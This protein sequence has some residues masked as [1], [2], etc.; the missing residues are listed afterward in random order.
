MLLFFVLSLV[1]GYTGRN[2]IFEQRIASNQFQS[3]TSFDAAEAGLDW[4][5]SQLNGSRI[6]NACV[7]TTDLTRDKF[8]DRYLAIDPANGVVTPRTDTGGAILWTACVFNGADWECSCPATGAPSLAAPVGTGS[9]PAFAVRFEA[10]TVRPGLVRAEVNGC[11]RYDPACLTIIRSAGGNPSDDCDSTMCALLA[12]N[13]ALRHVPVAALTA[14]GNVEAGTG[15]LTVV[16]A[17]PS[18]AV[19]ARA[20]GTIDLSHTMISA[21]GTPGELSKVPNDTGL[22][23]LI[24]DSDTC[25]NCLFAATFGLPPA[26]Y[27]RKQDV[28]EL[29]CTSGCTASDVRDAAALHPGRTLWLKGPGPGGGLD[30]NDDTTPVGSATDPITLIVEGPVSA[31]A[32]APRFFGVLYASTVNLGSGGGDWRGVVLS[33]GNVTNTGAA[34]VAFDKPLLDRLRFGQGSFVRVPGSWR[35]FQ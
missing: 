11:A 9:Y 18:S 1:A 4:A 28:V 27:R 14:R 25:T 6:D 13:S 20:G 2:L 34:T 22:Q 30:F 17:E 23:A 10:D 35:D 19:T 24:A 21:P 31:S 15:P 29:D 33:S 32:A 26:S 16:N 12:L 7:T 3:T 8:R 5:I